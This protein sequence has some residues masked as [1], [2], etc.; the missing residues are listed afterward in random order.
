MSAGKNKML[1]LN[2]STAKCMY[3]QQVGVGLQIKHRHKEDDL[4]PCHT[5][6]SGWWTAAR[7]EVASEAMLLF[8]I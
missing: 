3:T 6:S 2:S 4:P 8:T 5:T 1:E 7:A